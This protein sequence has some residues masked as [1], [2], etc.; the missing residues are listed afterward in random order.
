MKE[1][2]GK[3]LGLQVLRTIR[4]FGMIRRGDHVLVAVSGGA[5]SMALLLFLHELA[6]RMSL[7]LTA[8]HLNHGLRGAE[9]REDEEF[10]RR[11]C[12]DLGPA[13]VCESADVKT[14]AEAN[15]KNLEETAR[16][17]RYDFLRRAA[18]E[19]GADRI[20]TGHTLD[21]QA[22]TLLFRLLRGSGPGGLEGIHAV[23]DGRIIRPLLECPRAS[24]L[25]FLSARDAQWREDSSNRDLHFQRNRIRQELIPYLEKHFNPRLASVL[26][27]EASLVHAAYDFLEHAAAGCGWNQSVRAQD[28]GTSPGAAARGDP[29]RA[30]RSARIAAGHRGG[31]HPGS[32]RIMR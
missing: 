1:A 14:L 6:P 24:I 21:D 32:A 23:I 26:T 11:V 25:E 15:G 10:V 27:R 18:A 31:T 16:E 22:E 29:I 8:A 28:G 17:V 9:A 20:A 30:A 5:D 4:K 13:F 7:R 3:A 12:S 19:A 2:G